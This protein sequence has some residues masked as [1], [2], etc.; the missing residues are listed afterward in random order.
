MVY[1]SMFINEPIVEC[2]WHHIVRLNSNERKHVLWH[3]ETKY[4]PSP[5]RTRKRDIPP[6]E[7]NFRN[8]EVELKDLE[9]EVNTCS[10]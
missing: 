8:F 9:D 3:G 1:S 7:E 5:S 2:V 6:K 4:G 10:A